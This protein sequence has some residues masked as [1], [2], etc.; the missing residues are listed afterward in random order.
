[1]AGI[2]MAWLFINTGEI[3]G[4]TAQNTHEVKLGWNAST[5]KDVTGYR[6]HYG[7][8]SRTYTASIV[9]GNVTSGKVPGLVEGVTY[10]FAVIAITAAGLES[11]FSEE[12]SFKPG[13]HT[14]HIGIAANG[15]SVLLL[16][17]LIGIQY[18]IEASVDLNSWTLIA[19]VTIPQGGSLKF[20]DPDAGSHPRRFY[21]TRQRL[22]TSG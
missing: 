9:L 6:I 2:L 19:I 7:T 14:S 21:R 13:L 10:Y 3:R 16:S 15:E 11:G 12:V 22:T 20:S 18:D 4:Q 1:M 17:G 5:S 8:A